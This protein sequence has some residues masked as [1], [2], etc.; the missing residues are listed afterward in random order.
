MVIKGILGTM[1]ATIR[2]EKNIHKKKVRKM[3]KK[4]IFILV[5]LGYTS[6][7]TTYFLESYVYATTDRE[8]GWWSY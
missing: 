1:V 8:G 6:L 2:V 4:K 3:W 7:S 5:V